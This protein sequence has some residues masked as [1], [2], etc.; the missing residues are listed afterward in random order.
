MVG[1][2]GSSPIAPTNFPPHRPYCAHASGA[3]TAERQRTQLPREEALLVAGR[4]NGHGF[5]PAGA[6][7]RARARHLPL[8]QLR[9]LAPHPA[10]GLRTA[11]DKRKTWREQEERLV[12]RWTAANERH[13]MAL[14]GLSSP[15]AGA[16][17]KTEAAA[18]L[19]EVESLRR[20]IARLKVEFNQGRRY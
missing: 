12:A 18:A 6:R 5:A 2:V 20:E 11:M 17:V 9:R 16:E 4:R 15:E 13:R 19:A 14:S 10:S 1:V 3:N 7:R 8:R